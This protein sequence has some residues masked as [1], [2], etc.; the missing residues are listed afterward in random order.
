MKKWIIVCLLGMAVEG[1]AQ[2]S[3]FLQQYRVRVKEYNQDIRSAD[4]AIAMR[5]EN[6]KSARAD[7]LPSLSG[8][9]NFNYT[10]HPL[11]L[12]VAV[13]SLNEPLSFQ[14]RDV[15]YGASLSLLQPVYSGGALKAGYNK[16]VKESELSRY[17]KERVANDI[18][19]NADVYYWNKVACDERVRVA[20]AFKASVSTLVEV[21][22]HRV[23]EG[24]TDRND[25][26]M[27]EVRLNDA[28]Y[29]SER[30]RNEAEV[31]RLSLNALAGIPSGEQ[32]LTDTLVAVP[33]LAGLSFQ[34]EDALSRR[35]EM[36][37]AET[38]IGVQQSAARMANAR[39]LP[40]LSVGVD[41]N[42]SSPGYD[43]RADLDP[44]YSVYAKLSVPIFEWGKRRHTR[45]K[46][47]YQ[48]DIGKAMRL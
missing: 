17:E 26:L 36:Q 5:L 28:D 42:Y 39:Y 24:Y 18:V 19:Y 43:F 35:P 46:D 15:K 47:R 8:G 31:A 2:Q 11:E 21:V 38:N 13:P 22:R 40:S 45:N 32:I 9:A 14:G 33:S 44:N 10:G 41:G 3:A 37:M 1:H 12:S 29:R 48:V 23:S 30:A 27:A 20:E 34:V 7:F 25:L 4:Y 6:E 16:A